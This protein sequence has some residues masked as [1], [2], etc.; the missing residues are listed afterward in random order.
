[1]C[2]DCANLCTA[3]AANILQNQ[4]SKVASN[5]YDSDVNVNYRNYVKG[6]SMP[7]PPLRG[8]KLVDLLVWVYVMLVGLLVLV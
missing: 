5:I 4:L 2:R 8:F 7:I 1:M 3:V 6:S